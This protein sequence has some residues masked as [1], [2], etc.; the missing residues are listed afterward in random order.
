M[1]GAVSAANETEVMLS[2]DAGDSQDL[3]TEIIQE[4]PLEDSPQET[5][6]DNQTPVPTTIRSD[7]KNIVRGEDFSVELKDA[8]NA[9]LTGKTVEISVNSVS[10]NRTTDGNGVAK[11]KIDLNPGSYTVKYSFRG[12]GYLTSENSTS[13][14]VIPTST[15]KIK[16]SDL[17]GYAGLK[18]T[19]TVVLTVGDIP[20]EGRTVT[21]KINGKTVTKKTDSKGKASIDIDEAKGT[22][23]IS[24]SYDGEDNIKSSSGTSKITIKKGAP[25][26]ITKANS[27]I[28]RNKKANYFKIKLVDVNGNPLK[29]KKVTFKLNGKKYVRKTNSKGIASLKIKL[30]TGSYKIKVTFAKTSTY[31]KATKTFKIK[32]K[33]K[34]ARNNGMWL[35]GRDMKSVDL[36][37]LQKYGF[38]HVFLNFKALE[39]HGKAAVEEWVKDAKDHGIKVH[40]WMQVFYIDGKWQNPVKNGKVNTKLINSKVKQAKKYAKIKGISGVHFD[41]VRYPGNAHA[42]KNSIKAVNTF[43][44]KATKAVHKVNKK[45][46]VSAAVMPEPS[47]MKKYYGQDIP[48]MGKY[49]DAIVPMVYKGNYHAG[50]K[51]IKWVTKTFAKQ[52]KKAKIWTGLQTYKS[53]ATL[54]KLS[55][56]ELM[57]DADAAALGGAYGVI[58]FRFKLFNYINF[59]EV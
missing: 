10:Y 17:T 27:I 54:K 50:T 48:T 38:K 30:K 42:Y 20:L 40:L 15:S 11:L 58:L 49:L 19:Y 4:V 25:T 47:S 56:K 21:F 6:A 43:V 35:F 34:Q 53:D 7:D 8:S 12:E 1:A 9:P 5:V 33:P 57:G 22:Y 26:K 45:L 24:Y 51:W 32:V 39:R 37:K 13:I 28:Y 31:N 46:I 14:F 41:Y 29:S 2:D 23:T 55:A 36:D 52:S 16:A 3:S 59:N 18:N 44:K